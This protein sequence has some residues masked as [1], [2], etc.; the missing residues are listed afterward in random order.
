MECTMEA[1][2]VEILRRAKEQLA[3]FVHG[4]QEPE[5]HGEASVLSDL[6]QF[7]IVKYDNLLLSDG[8]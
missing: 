6:L 7:I 4:S 2:E 5:L 8:E 1:M 3:S